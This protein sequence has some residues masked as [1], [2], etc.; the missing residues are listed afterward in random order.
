MI[1][2]VKIDFN[3]YSIIILYTSKLINF[4]KYYISENK[5]FC[6][7]RMFFK[8]GVLNNVTYYRRKSY[9]YLYSYSKILRKV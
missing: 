1:V 6:V 4:N 9:K 8:L 5:Y 7:I 3:R 2:F